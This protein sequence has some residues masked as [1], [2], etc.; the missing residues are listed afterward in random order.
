MIK[1]PKESKLEDKGFIW[2]YK[3]QRDSPEWQETGPGSR[4]PGQVAGWSQLPSA[5]R[6]WGKVINLQGL[7]LV[8]AFQ[9][10][11]SSYRFHNLPKQHPQLKNTCSDMW[12]FRRHFWSNPSTIENW[13]SQK[14]AWVYS[15]RFE[16][17]SSIYPSLGHNL[18]CLPREK[19]RVPQLGK[20]LNKASHLQ[21]WILTGGK[22]ALIISVSGQSNVSIGSE[23]G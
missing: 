16:W 4:W 15:N 18:K 11:S 10:A 22:G 20:S 8:Y 1:Q 17:G 14:G 3:S 23:T 21:A 6:K 9:R 19:K 12:A 5:H 2:A 7:P 13:R